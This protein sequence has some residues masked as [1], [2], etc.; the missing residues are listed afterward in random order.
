VAVTGGPVRKLVGEGSQRRHSSANDGH[1]LVSLASSMTKPSEIYRANTDGSGVTTLT[2]TNDAFVSSFKLQPAEEVTWTG[3]L[4]A[5][6]AG[7][8]VKPAN[9]NPRKNISLVVL[10]HGGPQGAWNDNWGYRWNPQIYAGD[11]YVAF[12]PNPRAQLV[13]GE[14]C[15]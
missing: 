10:I 1:A 8:I 14:V 6:V 2:T 9:F 4:G 5:K 12:L 3:G 7:W 15:R 11:G 13:T